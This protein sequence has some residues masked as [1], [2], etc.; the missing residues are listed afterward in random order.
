M[1]ARSNNEKPNAGNS[2]A[3]PSFIIVLL[4]LTLIGVGCGAG[5]GFLILKTK[6]QVSATPAVTVPEKDIVSEPPATSR[7]PADAVEIALDPIVSSIGP[8]DKTK[9]RLEASM[10]VSK[11]GASS[12]LLKKEMAEDIVAFF[13]GVSLDDISGSRGFQNLREDLDDLARVRGRGTVYGLLISG[14]VVE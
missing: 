5:F 6:P 3:Q 12:P 1:A 4:I 9:M 13:R 2:A 14:F 7:Y 10:I 11:S 8:N